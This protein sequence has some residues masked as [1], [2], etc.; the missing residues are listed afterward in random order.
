[1]RIK[2]YKAA[3]MTDALKIVK[4]ELGDNALI[5]SSKKIKGRNGGIEVIAAID[6]NP[7]Q[8][9]KAAVP[10]VPAFEES[11]KAA[12]PKPASVSKRNYASRVYSGS[13]VK[14]A[15]LPRVTVP[16]FEKISTGENGE[17]IVD[18]ERVVMSTTPFFHNL[19][20]KLSRAGVQ[21]EIAD[22]LLLDLG[23][24]VPQNEFRTA[25]SAAEVLCKKLAGLF[26]VSHSSAVKKTPQIIALVGP[27]GVGKTTSIA[28]IA[29]R[30]TLQQQASVAL[31]SIDTYR[32]GAIDQLRTFAE[33]AEIPLKVAF[34]P[35]QLEY[36]VKSFDDCDYI[37]LD[38]TGRNPRNR[39]FLRELTLF[40]ENVDI[41]E[42]H[43]TLSATTRF[44]EL[45][46]IIACYKKIP[47]DHVLFTKIDEVMDPAVMLNLKK[48]T[49]KPVSYICNG[50][51]IPDDL[52][53]ASAPG[54]AQLLVENWDVDQWI[55]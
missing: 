6:D 33:I 28:K 5:L 27:T 8:P 26:N 47:F 21:Q 17:H 39:I 13:R 38:T 12:A 4:N 2:K 49:D 54:L 50:Q 40:L 29:A 18:S 15:A 32:I 36:I 31:V 14:P 7:L 10:P 51:N 24:S 11:A 1:M 16:S 43:L 19:K 30:M 22:A 48:L 3:S 34:S 42:V 25:D 55:S 37:F 53:E 35:Q 23:E 20:Q 52:I 45:E 44:A 41:A 46:D 9:L